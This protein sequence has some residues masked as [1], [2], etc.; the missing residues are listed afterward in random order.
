MKPLV[1][2]VMLLGSML[3]ADIKIPSAVSAAIE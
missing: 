2:L 1:A 3:A